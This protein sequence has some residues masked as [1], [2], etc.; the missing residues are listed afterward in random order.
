MTK[1]LYGHWFPAR[2]KEAVDSLDDYW[3]QGKL[4]DWRKKILTRGVDQVLQETMTA[5][6]IKKLRLELG[7]S[8]KE[9]AKQVGV[10]RVTI[11]RWETGRFR[12]HHLC[13]RQIRELEKRKGAA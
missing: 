12:P 11:T 2:N 13:L 3:E 1:D 6:Q 9:M 7:L 8:Q 5:D 10:S 4:L